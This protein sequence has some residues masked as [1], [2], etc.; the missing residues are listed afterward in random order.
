MRQKWLPY[1]L[2]VSDAQWT[3]PCGE[4]VLKHRRQQKTWRNFCP[5]TKR[6]QNKMFDEQMPG[7]KKARSPGIHTATSVLDLHGLPALSVVQAG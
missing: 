1:T 6:T 5:Q 4:R 2:E 3:R 7:N